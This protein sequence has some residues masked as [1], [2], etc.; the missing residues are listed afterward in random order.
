MT[1]N[2]TKM[3]MEPHMSRYSAYGQMT[4]LV[5]SGHISN[6]IQGFF[7]MGCFAPPSHPAF[8]LPHAHTLVDHS[9]CGCAATTEWASKQQFFKK[10]LLASAHM[11][12]F[13]ALLLCDRSIIPLQCVNSLFLTQPKFFTRNHSTFHLIQL[14]FLLIFEFGWWTQKMDL[15]EIC[16]VVLL[17]AV[18]C[19]WCSCSITIRE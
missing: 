19:V 11:H 3:G 16:L 5:Q 10:M 8:A 1:F 17:L 13:E 15:Q 6:S 14:P 12:S 7:V 9:D 18:N 4:G 2:F